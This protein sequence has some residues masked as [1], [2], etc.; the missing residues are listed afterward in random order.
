MLKALVLPAEA[1]VVLNRP[2]D[3]GA[4]EAVALGLEGPVVD[5]FRLFDFTERPRQDPLGRG[6]RD[7]DL[8]KGLGRLLFIIFSKLELLVL[9]I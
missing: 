7:L 4:E 6:Q 8:V 5:G 1:L 3:A 2:K 9:I